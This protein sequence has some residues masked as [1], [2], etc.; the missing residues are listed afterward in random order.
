M[1]AQEIYLQ[2]EISKQSKTQAKALE[3]ICKRDEAIRLKE[4]KISEL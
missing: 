4:S 1:E 3:I 2:E